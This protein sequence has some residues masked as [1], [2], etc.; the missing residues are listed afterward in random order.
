MDNL[1]RFATARA[2]DFVRA[3]IIVPGARIVP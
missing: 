2:A 3:G 1:D